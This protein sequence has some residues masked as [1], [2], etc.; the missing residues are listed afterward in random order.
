MRNDNNSLIE[1][2]LSGDIVGVNS[3]LKKSVDINQIDENGNTALIYAARFNRTSIARILLHHGADVSL[4]NNRGETAETLFSK[5]GV[6][7]D[8]LSGNPALP[9]IKF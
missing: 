9:K 6:N 4:I 1:A 5:H 2:I 3:L 7:L 8:D